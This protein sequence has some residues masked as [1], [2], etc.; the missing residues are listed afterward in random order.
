MTSLIQLI[1]VAAIVLFAVSKTFPNDH[2]LKKLAV[3]VIAG[4]AT[5]WDAIWP[6]IQGLL[7][8]FGG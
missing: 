1:I 6:A 3:V 8:G 5:A 7:S 2:W 4:A